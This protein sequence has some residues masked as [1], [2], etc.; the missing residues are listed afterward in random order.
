MQLQKGMQA[1]DFAL[2]DTDRN[3]VTLSSLKGKKV[4][5]L[6][7]PMAF[8]GVCTKELCAVRDGMAVYNN[9]DAVVLGISVD[10]PFTLAKFKEAE[11]LNFQLLSDFNKEVS[12]AYGAIYDS[13]IGWMKG[14][15]KRA[16]FLIDANSTIQYAEVLENAGDLP[17]FEAIQHILAA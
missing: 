9:S 3:Q 17:N 8:T 14:V 4:I 12:T 11:G 6:F 15:S 10:S 7:F 13:F 16:A 1:P 2:Y 5:L